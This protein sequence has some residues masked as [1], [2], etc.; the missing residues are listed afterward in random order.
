MDHPDAVT[1]DIF[2]VFRQ[3]HG[4]VLFSFEVVPEIHG[5]PHACANGVCD[6]GKSPPAIS[7]RAG[8]SEAEFVDT[9]CHELAHLACGIEAGH[10]EQW[11]DVLG[12][13]SVRYWANKIP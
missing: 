1:S 11:S 2:A 12:E 9:L 6:F 10:N 8:L 3:V 7:V 4:E 13:L 5:S